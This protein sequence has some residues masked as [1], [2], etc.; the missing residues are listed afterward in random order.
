[1]LVL[2]LILIRWLRLVRVLALLIPIVPPVQLTTPTLQPLLILLLLLLRLLPLL[3]CMIATRQHLP[4][5][6]LLLLLLLLLLLRLLPM[7]VVLVLMR[8]GSR[9]AK[10]PRGSNIEAAW[11]LKRRIRAQSPCEDARTSSARYATLPAPSAHCPSRA[12]TPTWTCL[13]EQAGALEDR[14]HEGN[15]LARRQKHAVALSKAHARRRAPQKQKSMENWQMSL[16]SKKYR[17]QIIGEK[18]EP[19]ASKYEVGAVRLDKRVD[20]ERKH[21]SI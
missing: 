9:G 12:S 14:A 15:I 21:R 1:M 10:R 6:P 2:V 20:T 8:E 18:G 7:R 13:R 16:L 19:A 5:F 11:L 17:R 3:V 4:L